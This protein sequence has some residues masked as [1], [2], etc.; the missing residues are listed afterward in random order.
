[1]ADAIGIDLADIGR[2]ARLYERYGDRF[3]DRVLGAEERAAFDKRG[4]KAVFLAGRF[5][6]KEA[7]V[8]AMGEY[9]TV[10]PPLSLLQ[11]LNDPTGRPYAKL[12]SEV[13]SKIG[14]ARILVSI[15]HEKNYA[16]GMVVITETR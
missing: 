6:A 14:P 16:V 9:L 7:L 4:D 12:P 11:I 10:R 15:S 1:M 2:L 8:K 3:V 5:A 13:E